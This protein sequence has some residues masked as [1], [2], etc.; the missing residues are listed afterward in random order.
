LIVLD[1][2]DI[3]YWLV[4][5]ITFFTLSSVKGVSCA[6]P[7][8]DRLDADLFFLF[9]DFVYLWNLQIAQVVRSLLLNRVVVI[10]QRVL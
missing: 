7:T 8:G 5:L 3:R 1:F 6:R 9:N 4:P 2:C 10:I